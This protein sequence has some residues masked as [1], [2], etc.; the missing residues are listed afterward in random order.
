MHK[1]MTT[2]KFESKYINTH[3]Y[4][5]ALMQ[6]GIEEEHKFSA[7]LEKRRKEFEKNRMKGFEDLPFEIRMMT[8]VWVYV[9]LLYICF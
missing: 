6:N 8:I 9:T 4:F 1:E 7:M 3:C 2:K 5:V